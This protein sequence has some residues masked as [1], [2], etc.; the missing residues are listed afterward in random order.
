MFY[1]YIL[2]NK[3]GQLY[4]GYSNDLKRRIAEHMA[5]K[6]ITTSRLQFEKLLYYEAYNNESLAKVREQKLKQFGSSYIGLLKRL[7]LK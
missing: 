1:V 7:D 3:N 2:Q 6:V 5:N 4:I